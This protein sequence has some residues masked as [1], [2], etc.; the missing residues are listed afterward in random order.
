MCVKV[1]YP[2]DE[3]SIASLQQLCGNLFSALLVPICELA[4]EIDFTSLPGFGEASEVVVV[5][6]LNISYITNIYIQTHK[7]KSTLCI[8]M[9]FSLIRVSSID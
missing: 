1:S 5:L 8:G 4:S 6:K 2:E 9:P 3:T 7:Y